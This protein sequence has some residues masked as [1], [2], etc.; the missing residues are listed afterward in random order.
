MTLR[1]L[2]RMAEHRARFDWS[3]TAEL[4]ALI[5]N[6]NRSSNQR[7]I[8]ADDINPYAERQ[9]RAVVKVKGVGILKTL[10]VDRKGTA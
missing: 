8:H 6:V 5:Y 1:Q 9:K 2:L 10:F 7:P 4:L 3:Q